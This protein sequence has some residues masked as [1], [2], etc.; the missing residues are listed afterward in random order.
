MSF[1]SPKEVL[2]T[3]AKSVDEAVDALTAPAKQLAAQLNLPLPPEPP[4]VS[5]LIENLPEL[6]LPPSPATTTATQA[7]ATTRT[8]VVHKQEEV[9]KLK[10]ELEAKPEEVKVKVV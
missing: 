8:V 2:R 5:T 3:V 10:E 9:G 7:T 4:K 1:P 6:P